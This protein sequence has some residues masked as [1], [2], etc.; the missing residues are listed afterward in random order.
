MAAHLQRAI[1]LL[2][3]QR[4][5]LAE[6]ELRRELLNNPNHA[7]THAL[8][9][10]C[11]NHREQYVEATQA[12]EQAIAL[13][14]DYAWAYYALA[15]VLYSRDRITE[16]ETVIESAIQL[17]PDCADYFSL[18]AAI[19]YERQRWSQSLQTAEQGLALSPD[20]VGCTNLQAMALVK[21]GRQQE[22]DT[23][24][25]S[26]LRHDPD[27][28]LTHANQGWALL[29]QS[30]PETA[31]VHFREALRL[32]PELQFARQGMVEALK[33]RHW[34]YR[35]MLRYF[36]WMSRLDRRLQWGIILGG[37]IGFRLLTRL[38]AAVPS[39]APWL[40]GVLALYIGFVLLTWLA[41]PL[42]T[43]LL[44]LDSWGRLSLTPEQVAMSNWVGG[45]LLVALICLGIALPLQNALLLTAALI[46]AAL[47]LPLSAVYR[48]P[49]G[50]PRRTMGSF[51]LI[52]GLAGLSGLG[53]LAAEAS[54]VS[55]FPV[56]LIGVV[57]GICLLIFLG[58][59]FLS[60]WVAN[61]LI[62]TRPKR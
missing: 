30:Q 48:C 13:A 10:L 42:F 38:A 56:R 31:V 52:L 37:Y 25:A 41:D 53:L 3:Q 35:A 34:L 32:N 28:A 57:R 6:A 43:L 44:R 40:I 17:Q 51:T 23:A 58:G 47:A 61:A 11:L 21:L 22:A 15:Q 9:S 24:I 1:V 19:Q 46:V 50:W 26:A 54:L 18:L 62:M 8:L 27:N 33:A 55:V 49:P 29:H 39:L 36:L 2:E 4:Y 45:S 16:A 20:H 60:G 7:L 14:P 5:D 59:I 12:A